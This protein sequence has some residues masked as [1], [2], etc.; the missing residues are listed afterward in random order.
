MLFLCKVYK[1]N[2]DMKRILFDD[3]EEN[4]HLKTYQLYHAKIITAYISLPQR[5]YEINLHINMQM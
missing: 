4:I 3:Y 2:K 5:M 1:G